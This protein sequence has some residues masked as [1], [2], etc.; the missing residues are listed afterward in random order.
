MLNITRP[1]DS[2]S[3]L[4]FYDLFVKPK[5]KFTAEA[6]SVQVLVVMAVGCTVVHHLLCTELQ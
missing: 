5:Y 6:S 1:L 2:W 4:K 3:C